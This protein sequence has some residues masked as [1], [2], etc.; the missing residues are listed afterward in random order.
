M[1]CLPSVLSPGTNLSGATASLMTNTP[2]TLYSA[3]SVLTVSALRAPVISR[4]LSFI[5]MIFLC[6]TFS[7]LSDFT[8][9]SASFAFSAS[10]AVFDLKELMSAASAFSICAPSSV[11]ICSVFPA[12]FPAGMKYSLSQSSEICQRLFIISDKRCCPSLIKL[13]VTGRAIAYTSS[14]EFILPRQ[15]IFH[16][17]AAC[18]DT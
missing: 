11:F 6:P 4:A 14:E 9:A 5:K 16:G 15:S 18:K 2:S 3:L 1:T 17:N 13:S 10:S 7:S 12:S 8:A